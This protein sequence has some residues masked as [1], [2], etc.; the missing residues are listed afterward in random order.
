[1]FIAQLQA[2]TSGLR[3]CR[4]KPGPQKRNNA[5]TGEKLQPCDVVP[6]RDAEGASTLSGH[7]PLVVNV[8]LFQDKKK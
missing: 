7:Q 2:A 4:S 8:L 1:M 6:A 3:R 5:P